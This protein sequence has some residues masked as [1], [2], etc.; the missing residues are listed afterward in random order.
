MITAAQ[1]AALILSRLAGHGGGRER[2]GAGGALCILAAPDWEVCCRRRPAQKRPAQ[3]VAPAATSTLS[4]RAG[5]ICG[6]P[7]LTLP[8]SVLFCQTME[9]DKTLEF[10]FC[11][12]GR[13]LVQLSLCS[14]TS[15]CIHDVSTWC[16]R[17]PACQCGAVGFCGVR[18]STCSP[19]SHIMPCMTAITAILPVP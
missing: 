7:P 8:P 19:H 2:S 14:H 13:T 18:G 1:A 17:A 3:A 16:C 12:G 11:T 10:G 4:C 5:G 6:E 9:P 15:S